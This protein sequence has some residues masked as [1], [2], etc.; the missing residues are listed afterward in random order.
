MTSVSA[1][2]RAAL[3][4]P[5]A[6]VK[7]IVALLVAAEHPDFYDDA[8]IADLRQAAR[9][10]IETML[11]VLAENI[12]PADEHLEIARVAGRRQVQQ[13]LPLEGVL[14]AYRLAGQA[15][16]EHFVAQARQT[17]GGVADDL[18]D[19]ATQVWQTIDEFCTAASEAFRQAE[20]DFSTRDARQQAAVL[21][22]LLDGR[23]SDPEFAR[24]A[25]RALG[26]HDDERL[27]CLVGVAAPEDGLAFD[28]PRERLLA[29]GITS[30]WSPLA[31]GE[32]GL[33]LLT[34][35]G[36]GRVRELLLPAV[37]SQAGLSPEFHHLS[38]LP[39]ARRLAEV[40]ARSA[41]AR[42]GT[43]RVL[44]DDLVAATVVDSPLVADWVHTRTVGRLLAGAGAEGSV[45]LSTIRAFIDADGSLNAAA[46]SSFVHRN[47]MLYRLNKIDKLTGL[48]CRS[49]KDQVLWVLGLK[50]HDTRV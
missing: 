2:S 8:G 49:L 19:G 44:D 31:S 12:T 26:V 14:R 9:G 37:R 3:A 42:R 34:T 40:A 18:I 10:G 27:V 21:A 36:I 16:W 33:V 20:R 23:G 4:H 29:G 30:V 7:R 46:E 39:R 15:L 6:L 45:L 13:G 1:L 48:T 32:V 11:V 28:N 38:E 22:A 5:D 43:L 47:T 50:E 17:K 25:A 41:G 35:G 24:D